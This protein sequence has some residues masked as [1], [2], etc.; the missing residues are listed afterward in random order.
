M[1][2]IESPKKR[3]VFS[4]KISFLVFSLLPFWLVSITPK[5]KITKM[6]PTYTSIWVMAKKSAPAKTYNP[7][8]PKKVKSKLNAAYSTFLDQRTTLAER[9]VR[10]IKAMKIN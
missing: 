3:L 5:I 4:L 10:R 7:A 1:I 9:T 8:M 6:P 2:A